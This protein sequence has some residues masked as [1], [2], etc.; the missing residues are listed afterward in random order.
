MSDR[1]SSNESTTENYDWETVD[2]RSLLASKPVNADNPSRRS[3]LRSGMALGSAVLGFGSLSKSAKAASEQPDPENLAVKGTT[4]VPSTVAAQEYS[5]SR[6][7]SV[8]AE[9]EDAIVDR[10]GLEHKSDFALEVTTNDPDL[11]RGTPRVVFSGYGPQTSSGPGRFEGSNRGNIDRIGGGVV[12]TMTVDVAE[13]NN[14]TKR[15][16]VTAFAA[17]THS[18]PGVTPTDVGKGKQD[19]L[20]KWYSVD[21]SGHVSMEHTDRAMAQIAANREETDEVRT[22]GG[23]IDAI[24]ASGCTAIVGAICDRATGHVSKYLCVKVCTPLISSLYGYPACAAGCVILV[25]VINNKGCYVGAAG[26]CAEVC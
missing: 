22:Q 20:R 17:T 24:C 25:D 23:G 26:I 12:V 13:A 5:Q 21:N 1:R 19:L 2:R 9:L 10:H 11:N 4:E 14:R 18:P 6:S 15:R 16:P 3:L 7:K 8:V